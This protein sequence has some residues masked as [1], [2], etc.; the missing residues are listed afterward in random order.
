MGFDVVAEAA[1]KKEAIILVIANDI[2]PKTHKEITLVAEKNEIELVEIPFSMDEI[3]QSVNKRVGVMAII[4]KGFS[5]KLKS[6]LPTDN[7]EE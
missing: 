4:D 5:T 7:M 2:S 1:K 3:W 6:L